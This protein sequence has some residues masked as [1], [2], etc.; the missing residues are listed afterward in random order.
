M[1]L[2]AAVPDRPRPPPT[3]RD[4]RDAPKKELGTGDDDESSETSAIGLGRAPDSENR[5]TDDVSDE[6]ACALL[7]LRAP[8]SRAELGSV[9]LRRRLRKRFLTPDMVRMLNV[10]LSLARFSAAALVSV[11]DGVTSSGAVL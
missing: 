9:G 11:S 10:L 3:R 4:S 6:S 2:L 8:F 5:P 1:L 7:L